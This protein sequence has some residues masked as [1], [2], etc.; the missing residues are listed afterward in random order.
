MCDSGIKPDIKCSKVSKP[1]QAV[2]NFVSPDLTKAG[3]GFLDLTLPALT[4][5]NPAKSNLT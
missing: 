1:D 5:P 4:Y 3:K 2:P